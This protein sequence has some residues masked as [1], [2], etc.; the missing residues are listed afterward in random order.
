MCT[1]HRTSLVCDWTWTATKG[2]LPSCQP[3][4]KC[5]ELWRFN[6]RSI[7]LQGFAKCFCKWTE[8]TECRDNTCEPGCSNKRCQ[9]LLYYQHHSLL[10]NRNSTY[11]RTCDIRICSKRSYTYTILAACA[12]EIVTY[13]G[14]IPISPM[15]VARIEA[16]QNAAD[17]HSLL[18]L[19][20]QM[21]NNFWVLVLVGS[22]LYPTGNMSRSYVQDIWLT[23]ETV[24]LQMP[25]SVSSQT[26]NGHT[27][28]VLKLKWSTSA[29]P[30][31]GSP[32]LWCFKYVQQR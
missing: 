31:L 15:A 19:I 23:W 12:G 14:S 24:Q 4:H 7:L 13:W 8:R 25:S 26:W 17:F 3:V 1:L 16:V 30:S 22:A 27:S 32:C 10:S 2:L 21:L 28:K 29:P 11:P 6:S 18:K 9:N 5:C 20:E